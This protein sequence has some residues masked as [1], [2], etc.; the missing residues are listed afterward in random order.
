MFFTRARGFCDSTFAM[1]SQYQ[2][3]SSFGCQYQASSANMLTQSKQPAWQT[4]A[5]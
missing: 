3:P 4:Y 1:S 2:A 5:L